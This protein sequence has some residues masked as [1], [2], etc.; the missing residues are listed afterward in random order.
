MSDPIACTPRFLP[1]H[2]QAAAAACAVANNPA[3]TPPLGVAMA[4]TALVGGDSPHPAPPEHLA[5]LVS[6][7]WGSGGVR[8]TVG[9]LE[10]VG[11]D[12]AERILT[13]ANAW[14]QFCNVLFTR[15]NGA[16]AQVRITLRG[17][18]YWSYLGTDVL[19]IP[20]NE[21][22]MC[23]QDFGMRTPESEY[24]RVVRH[25]FGHTLGF[26]HEH[27]RRELVARLD[28]RKT[29]SYFRRTQGWSAAMVQQQILT[30]LEERSIMGTTRADA[31]S[32]MAYSIP[33]ACLKP[34]QPPIPG[35]ADIDPVD[36]EFAG[37]LYPLPGGAM[38][39]PPIMAP[40]E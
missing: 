2:Q 15:G 8:L 33:S 20:P 13:H 12:L 32:I 4:V 36:Q 18:G 34:G 1:P 26:P 30:P 19:S 7:Y 23:L 28:R 38:P 31:T 27:M 17:E 29:T 16:E 35:G 10:Q 5:V 37:R 22:T 39:P 3:N 25:E 40:V 14:G 21:P 24:R 9:F 6:R 11:D